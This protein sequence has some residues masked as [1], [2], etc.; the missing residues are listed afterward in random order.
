MTN[1]Q[2]R[3]TDFKQ[4]SEEAKDLFESY[5]KLDQKSKRLEGLYSFYARAGGRYGG[6]DKRIVEVFYGNK[7]FDSFIEI[8]AE[9]R[10]IKKLA[11]ERGST[12]LYQR[13]D[14]GQVLC[15]LYP[16]TSENFHPIED[17]IFL[18]IIKNPAELKSKSQWHWKI[19]QAYM[20]CT[21]LDGNPSY[22]QKILVW[23]LR[24]FKQ[25]IVD[26]TLQK[27]KA[28][29]FFCGLAKYVLTV[30][31]SGFIIF[32][33]TQ[34][35]DSTSDDQKHQEIMNA[36]SRTFNGLQEIVNTSKIIENKMDVHGKKINDNLKSLDYSISENAT[37]I[38]VTIKYINERENNKAK[39]DK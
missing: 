23:Y 17:F 3:Y 39:D 32:F 36:N 14:D 31:L 2:S 20:E 24:N 8:G 5:S 1:R 19:F 34:S 22:Y 26:K 12:L 29:V 11:M 16:A 7:P 10:T 25:Y 38:V 33:V 6:V 27:C 15:S 18:D 4:F 35:K 30:G 37:K 28:T 9:S 13:T 21:C